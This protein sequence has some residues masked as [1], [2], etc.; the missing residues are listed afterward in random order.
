[1]AYAPSSSSALTDEEIIT[2]AKQKFSDAS[3]AFERNMN[4]YESDIKFGRLGE[5]WEPSDVQA[6]QIQ[7]R[8]TLTINRLPSFIRQVVNDARQ[9]KPS[10]KVHPIDDKA[11]PD[12][13]E[14]LN[15]IIR[16]IEQVSKA[17]LAYDTALDCCASGGFGYFR[18]GMEYADD[19]TFDMDITIDRIINPLTIYPDPKS[20]C[21]D[22]SDWDCCFV[23]E[24]MPREEFEANYP[25]AQPINW[26][27]GHSSRDDSSWFDKDQIRIA[28]YWYREETSSTIHLMAS[29]DVIYDS[30]YEELQDEYEALG[31]TIIETR[32]TT[33]YKVTQY[34]MN[35]QEILETNPWPGQYIPIIPVYGEEVYA[36]GERT[37]LS[38]IHF[39]KDA[40]RTYNYWRTTTTELIAMAPKAPW[41]GPTGAFNSDLDRWQNANTETIPF[42]EYDGDVPPQR[43]PFAGPP[44]GALQE[45][46]N[47]SDD[48]KSVM[49]LHDAALGAQSNEISGVAIGKR[50]REGDTS[51]FHFVDNMAR[52]IRHAGVIIVGLIPHVYSRA[53]M[54][55]VLGE[56]GSV[57]TVAVNQPITK[58]QEMLQGEAVEQQEAM[59]NIYD[60]TVGKY[61]V[62]VKS[63]PSYTTQR[64]EARSSMLALLQAF[65][66]AAAVTG[67]LV[68]ES[69]DWP[70]AD[71]FAKRLKSM[72]PP[73]VIDEK[74]DPRIGQMTQQMQGMEQVINQ[75]MADREGKQAEIQVDRE[76]LQIDN[77]KVD[78]DYLRAETD[79]MEAQIKAKEAEIKATAALMSEK[80]DTP[81][82]LKQM[83]IKADAQQSAFE[84]EFNQQKIDIDRERLDLERQKLELEKYKADMSMMQKN[85][86]PPEG[87]STEILIDL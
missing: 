10:I 7:G 41:V 66:Q 38:L 87:S 19:D 56:D 67:D 68:A 61:D 53:R 55:R 71:V 5:Q 64:E 14:V 12:T 65:P 59:E 77:R 75:L 42:L 70:N 49:G 34:I 29:G 20:M 47:A 25:D 27:A 2:K 32:E 60:L 39:S 30:V 84:A 46:L 83:D 31:N 58:E 35:G 63:G 23:T 26:S 1:M 16:N 44:A 22:S 43:Q 15:G 81:I 45:A 74:T 9:N 79:R 85:S 52:A 28:E 8:P 54:V 57:Q 11:D 72:L 36:D 82:V 76:K 17:D 37:F 33:S 24:M 62:T 21:A 50:V 48:M 40:Q 86:T 51:T 73:G 69:M 3:E 13:A 6:R 18:I 78:V 80:D 4:R